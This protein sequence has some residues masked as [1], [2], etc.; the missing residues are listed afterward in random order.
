MFTIYVAPSGDIKSFSSSSSSSCPLQDS[1]PRLEHAKKQEQQ[2][3]KNQLSRP[4][5]PPGHS[6]IDTLQSSIFFGGF[7]SLTREIEAMEKQMAAEAIARSSKMLQQQQQQQQQQQ[8]SEQLHSMSTPSIQVSLPADTVTAWVPSDINSP[9]KRYKITVEEISEVAPRNLGQD[10]DHNTYGS[11]GISKQQGGRDAVRGKMPLTVTTTA[12]MPSSVMSWLLHTMQEEPTTRRLNSGEV[13]A[14]HYQGNLQTSEGAKVQESRAD[15]SAAVR[16]VKPSVHEHPTAPAVIPAPSRANT[17]L[18][19]AIALATAAVV[20]S[21]NNTNNDTSMELE[22]EMQVNKAKDV[23]LDK[24]S[25]VSGDAAV[26]ANHGA[27]HGRRS[28]PPRHRSLEHGQ[29]FTQ[30]TIT[31]PDGIVESK[32]V[33]LNRETGIA[34]T[35]VRITHPD[36][37]VQESVTRKN[38]SAS[39]SPVSPPPTAAAS[40]ALI[41]KHQQLQDQREPNDAEPDVQLRSSIRERWAQR[42]QE[43]TERREGRQ[44]RHRERQERRQ[45]LREIEARQREATA[46][47]YGFVYNGGP[48]EDTAEGREAFGSS[49]RANAVDPTR[50]VAKGQAQDEDPHRARM[51]FHRYHDQQYPSAWRRRREERQRERERMQGNKEEEGCGEKRGCGGRTW[52][53]RGYLRRVEQEQ[54]SE[55][56]HN[57]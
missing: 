31:R 54:E 8:H 56:R 30:T 16:A 42:R 49:R 6:L 51:V 19:H 26:V 34:E 13:D 12:V 20:A 36:G 9:L 25:Q 55:P 46:A 2:Q 40:A 11:T 33:T 27:E 28:W 1:A 14:G 7:G 37:S 53:P 39:N 57:V 45:E 48:A 43:R 29:T 24:Q 47:A 23:T 35:R 44:E 5:R 41:Q 17:D 10:H 18:D 3:I 22:K 4:Q 52:P 32:T 21:A 38:K 15:E 50:D